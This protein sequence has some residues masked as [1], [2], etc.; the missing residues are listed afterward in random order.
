MRSILTFLYSI[1]GLWLGLALVGSEPIS[2]TLLQVT[3]Y[4]FALY[5]STTLIFVLQLAAQKPSRW[6]L[7][8]ALGGCLCLLLG[9]ALGR[10]YVDGN[11]WHKIPE[12]I[13]EFFTTEPWWW[14]WAW[15]KATWVWEQLPFT[16]VGIAM[17]ALTVIV[18]GVCGL[19]AL[20]YAGN[21]IFEDLFS[22]AKTL[23]KRCAS[24]LHRD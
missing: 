22:L 14:E 8:S 24:L 21:L 7:L 11:I 23:K 13:W 1:T 19:C 4:T 18:I 9:V 20:G 3:G 16:E 10:L 12:K 17:T 6:F 15:Q 5:V 2:E